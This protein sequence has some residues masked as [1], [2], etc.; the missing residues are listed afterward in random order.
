MINYKMVNYKVQI[1]PLVKWAGGKTQLLDTITKFLPESFDRYIEP[2]I[3]GGALYFFLEPEKPI[4]IDKN[5]ELINF[6]RVVRDNLDEMIEELTSYKNDAEFYYYIRKLQPHQ[7]TNIQRAARFL[8]LN[9]TGY[10]GLWRVNKKGEFNVPF[11][12]YKNPKLIDRENL[13]RAREL[14]KRTEILFGD[15]DM[16]LDYAD[17]NTFIYF[18]PPYHPLSETSSFTSYTSDD[19]TEKDQIRLA[20]IFCELDRRGSK[21]MLSN[22]DTPFIKELYKGYNIV[23]VYAKRAINCRPDKRGPIS[24]LIIRNYS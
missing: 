8:Y 3:G 4:I 9:K 17:K 16:C 23:K 22:S 1:K 2:F 7:L 24:E 12:K 19:F 14:L 18:D 21:L 11:G 5:H 20:N 15:F 10:N 13:M 6:Y